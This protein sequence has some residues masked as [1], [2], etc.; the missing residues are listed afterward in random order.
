MSDC[1]HIKAGNS[2]EKLLALGVC[3]CR[4][5]FYDEGGNVVVGYE[6]SEHLARVRVFFE[7]E[8][9]EFD[10]GG[11]VSGGGHGRRGGGGG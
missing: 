7:A 3:D 10:G 2:V 1:T 9:H 5:L 11:A 6:L 4:G 8:E